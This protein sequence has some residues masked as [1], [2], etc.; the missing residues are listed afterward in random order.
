LKNPDLDLIVDKVV[1]Y[2]LIIDKSMQYGSAL[3]RLLALREVMLEFL[4]PIESGFVSNNSSDF[5][6]FIESRVGKVVFTKPFAIRIR[7]GSVR[8]FV[9]GME[10]FDDQA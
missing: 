5:K 10:I 2:T 9:S 8:L 1:M 7:P 6:D 4:E 3:D